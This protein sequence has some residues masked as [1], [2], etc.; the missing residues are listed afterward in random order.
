MIEGKSY[1]ITI[2]LNTAKSKV[3]MR[4][5]FLEEL[6]NELYLFKHPAGYKECFLKKLHG[7]N[8]LM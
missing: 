1:E 2:K 4:M 8:R 3:K 6:N 7:I 5:K